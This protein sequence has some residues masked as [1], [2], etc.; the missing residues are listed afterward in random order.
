MCE[1][2]GVC[3]SGYYAWT[4]REKSDR[5]KEYDKLIPIVQEAHKIWCH[6]Q[7]E[8]CQIAL[9]KSMIG[10]FDMQRCN[11]KRAIEVFYL[12]IINYVPFRGLLPA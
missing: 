8:I 7:S 2:L 11:V 5:Q 1:I 10:F 12:L 3:R 4:K 6:R 9:V